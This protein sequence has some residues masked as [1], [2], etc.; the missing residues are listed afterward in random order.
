MFRSDLLPCFR[1]CRY[2]RATAALAYV[3]APGRGR[4]TSYDI[5]G[6]TEADPP[7]APADVAPRVSFGP[8]PPPA[9]SPA[10]ARFASAPSAWLPT[11]PLGEAPGVLSRE[12]ASATPLFA[13]SAFAP[14]P[15]PSPFSSRCRCRC[16]STSESLGGLESPLAGAPP[17]LAAFPPVGPSPPSPPPPPPA[18]PR[19]PTPPLDDAPTP[20]SAVVLVFGLLRPG[21]DT[22]GETI[23]LSVKLCRLVRLL[24]M[25]RI[26]R[27]LRVLRLT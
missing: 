11:P 12:G 3:Q 15:R 22:F 19:A 14:C 16:S 9:P 18:F 4:P 25:R 13:P 7:F 20:P 23:T 6:T 8:G 10:V 17:S 26:L 1:H 2:P 21:D 24:R 5:T 27:R